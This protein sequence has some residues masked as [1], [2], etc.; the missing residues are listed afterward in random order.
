[1]VGIALSSSAFAQSAREIR[2]DERAVQAH[3]EK[4]RDAQD[5]G[6]QSDIREAR[7]DLRGARQELREDRRDQRRSAYVSPYRNWR[8]SSLS[9]GSRL[10]SGFYGSRYTISN[11]AAHGLHHVARNQRW[12]RYGDDIVLVNVR[13]GRVLQVMPNRYWDM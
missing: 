12:V 8:Y 5:R 13:S 1:M 4:L 10:R 11:P 3:Q 6:R 7:E 9:E 2:K